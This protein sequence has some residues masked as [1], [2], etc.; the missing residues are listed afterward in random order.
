MVEGAGSVIF[1]VALVMPRRNSNS[2]SASGLL[3][4]NLRVRI[5]R[6]EL[7]LMAV[8]VAKLEDRGLDRK[9]IDPLDEAS[10]IGTAPEFAVGNDLQP[11]LL[12]HLHDIADAAIG[13]LCKMRVIDALAGVLAHVIAECLAQHL[14]PQQA[15]DMVG[16]ERGRPCGFSIIGFLPGGFLFYRSIDEI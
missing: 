1:G 2:S 10:P 6:G 15:A 8:I 11:D 12:L 5:G 4:R 16:A 13:N 14:R 7:D 3:R 9:A